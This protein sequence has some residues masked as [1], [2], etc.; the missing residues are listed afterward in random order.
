MN[1]WQQI[2][3]E[4]VHDIG[5]MLQGR[6][7]CG[8]EIG[9]IGQA[10]RK[11]Q[12]C[13]E[14]IRRQN[15]S[16][17]V[18]N[19]R[20]HDTRFAAFQH[21]KC[22]LNHCHQQHILEHQEED[23]NGAA[24]RCSE[25]HGLAHDADGHFEGT[26]RK[27]K[28]SGRFAPFVSDEY[29]ASDTHDHA[30]KQDHQAVAQRQ[31]EYGDNLSSQPCTALRAENQIGSGCVQP[32]EGR[33]HQHHGQRR[34]QNAVIIRIAPNERFKELNIGQVGAGDRHRFVGQQPAEQEAKQKAHV[35]PWILSE[36]IQ[37]PTGTDKRFFDATH[38]GA[39]PFAG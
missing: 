39:P 38:V 34:K 33:E 15:V 21:R 17:E 24:V 16:S 27:G 4:V 8:Q 23:L 26:G 9:I 25:F 37:I 32:R 2:V 29:V 28:H 31:D 5:G 18:Y 1:P 10:L 6:Q 30:G 13:H 3:S 7:P 12:P 36:G 22:Q 14:A 20:S 19:Q 11:L 35:E